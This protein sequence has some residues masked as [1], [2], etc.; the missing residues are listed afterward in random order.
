MLSFVA[1]AVITFMLPDINRTLSSVCLSEMYRVGSATSA[2]D[3][4]RYLDT[5]G[6]DLLIMKL[7][8]IRRLRLH[9]CQPSE[10]SWT[11]LI[12]ISL[13]AMTISMTVTWTEAHGT[14]IFNVGSMQFNY[15]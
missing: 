7:T 4:G 14:E 10:A 15:I 8:Q 9:G 11:R 6:L 5:P 13:L 12:L 2:E 3:V 1:T